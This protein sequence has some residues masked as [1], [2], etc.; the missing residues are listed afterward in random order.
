MN[1]NALSVVTRLPQ[2]Y[3]L[4]GH[5]TGQ[6]VEALPETRVYG[7]ES[8]RGLKLL[9]HGHKSTHDALCI[10]RAHLEG[11]QIDSVILIWEGE[12][13]LFL[14]SADEGMALCALKTA[15]AA[16]AENISALYPF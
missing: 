2:H 16:I 4:S 3:R 6:Q 14:R 11:L 12:P 9:S 10:I 5:D 7:E 8:L 13:C 15:G 1:S